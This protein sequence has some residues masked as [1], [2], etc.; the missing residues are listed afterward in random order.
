MII[1]LIRCINEKDLKHSG[2]FRCMKRAIAVFLNLN[3]IIDLK[4]V[5]CY[6]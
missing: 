6:D 3:K 2:H 1:Y 5:K 4:M